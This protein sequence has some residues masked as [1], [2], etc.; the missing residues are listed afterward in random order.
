MDSCVS[1]DVIYYHRLILLTKNHISIFLIPIQKLAFTFL[2]I[3]LS[4][5]SGTI[6][7]LV[8]MRWKCLESKSKFHIDIDVVAKTNVSCQLFEEKYLW[9]YFN[10]S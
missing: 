10:E 8:C 5:M 2:P 3:G 6:F 1:A 4:L 9:N 7:I